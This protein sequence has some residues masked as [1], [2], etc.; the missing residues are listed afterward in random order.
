MS[1]IASL[2]D[3]SRLIRLH[4]RFALRSRQLAE[5]LHKRL[6]M[7]HYFMSEQSRA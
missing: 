1:A 4:Q 7:S 2:T 5:L 6:E 3:D